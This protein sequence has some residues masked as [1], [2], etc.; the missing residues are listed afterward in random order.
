MI[1]KIESNMVFQAICK[2]MDNIIGYVDNFSILI[3][4]FFFVEKK[5]IFSRK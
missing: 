3:L 1:V 4:I 2:D 5:H